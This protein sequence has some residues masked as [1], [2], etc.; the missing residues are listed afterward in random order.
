MIRLET[1]LKEILLNECFYNFQWE[2][3]YKKYP[4]YVS[5]IK[6]DPLVKK[7]GFWQYASEEVLDAPDEDIYNELGYMGGTYCGLGPN[8]FNIN[9]VTEF[10]EKLVDQEE[11]TE[12]TKDKILYLAK[13]YFDN[14]PN[15]IDKANKESEISYWAVDH[16]V[17]VRNRGKE[18][19]LDM[20]KQNIEQAKNKPNSFIKKYNITIDDILNYEV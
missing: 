10:F 1:L 16:S 8:D 7:N 15:E 11:I 18:K 14:Y 6:N 17:N 12:D 20:L 5:F 3:F 9:G 19:A 4:Q 13:K 2:T